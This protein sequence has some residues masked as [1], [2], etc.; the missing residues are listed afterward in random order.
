MGALRKAPVH[1]QLCAI[2]ENTKFGAGAD[3]NNKGNNTMQYRNLAAEHDYIMQCR[4]E[5]RNAPYDSGQA[6][7]FDRALRGQMLYQMGERIA[8]ACH[9]NGVWSDYDLLRKT[10][11]E[12]LRF[13]NLGVV[14][15][16]EIERI[17]SIHGYELAKETTQ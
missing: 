14:S 13:T 10:P 15:L 1:R 16:K 3:N 12:L 8:N 4:Q 2:I 17:L 9:R 5:G 6:L 11:A 7:K